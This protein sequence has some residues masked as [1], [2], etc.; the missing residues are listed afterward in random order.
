[1]VSERGSAGIGCSCPVRPLSHVVCRFL[2]LLPEFGRS[3]NWLS[4]SLFVWAKCSCGSQTG[5]A[6]VFCCLSSK[7]QQRLCWEQLFL[8]SRHRSERL[9]VT[10]VVSRHPS[11]SSSHSIPAALEARGSLQAPSY[12]SQ[13]QN[14]NKLSAPVL[15]I[16]CVRPFGQARWKHGPA[17][18]PLLADGCLHT[19]CAQ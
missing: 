9:N 5:P 4:R 6:W 12:N 8:P 3:L 19:V 17:L 18:H 13:T 1:M 7:R 15:G 14:Q 11:S 10:P 16:S 2:P